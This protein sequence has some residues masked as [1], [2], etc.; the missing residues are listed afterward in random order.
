MSFIFLLFLLTNSIHVSLNAYIYPS[1]IEQISLS[2][3]E[4]ELCKNCTYN[5]L[6]SAGRIFKIAGQTQEAMRFFRPALFKLPND[7]SINWELGDMYLLN[8]DFKRGMAGF[9]A[10]WQ[11]EQIHQKKLWNGESLSQKTIL[12][13]C[14]WGLGDTFMYL[15]YLPLLKD[16]G[17]RVICA[18]QK[19]LMQIL[20]FCTFIDELIPLKSNPMPQFDYQVPITYLPEIFGTTIETI[21]QP[22][23]YLFVEQ[24][25]I[26]FWATKLKNDHHF[27]IG[28]CWN[29]ENRP[30]PQ[31]WTRSIELSK[32]IPLL[33][34]PQITFYSLQTGDE[35]KQIDSLPKSCSIVTFD[36][37]FDKEHG[38]FVDTAALMKN[39]DLVLTIDTS[40]AHLAGALGVPVWVMLP[41]ANE[42]RFFKERSDSPWYPTM[43]LFRQLARND[44]QTVIE[45]IM[46]AIKTHVQ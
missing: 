10:R 43:T 37:S 32:L 3:H 24:E 36:E 45:Q 7:L 42:W 28:L 35:L 41:Y 17:A 39:L 11:K 38:A 14:Q 26:D 30:D 40:I 23:P 15:R 44:W 27:K 22:I 29:G 16:Q 8:G 2:V 46:L 34:I 19:P 18:C 1:L 6:F 5:E 12:I 31:T 33:E 4:E 20:S 13:Y 9:R 25:R 21:P